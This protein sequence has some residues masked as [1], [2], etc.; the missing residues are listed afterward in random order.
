M[1]EFE[2]TERAARRVYGTA[3]TYYIFIR[4]VLIEQIQ[5]NRLTAKS[6]FI[7][8]L[9]GAE[10]ALWG[11]EIRLGK[12]VIIKEHDFLYHHGFALLPPSK[13][14]HFCT[15]FNMESAEIGIGA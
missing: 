14:N 12:K 7:W 9:L 1:G 10:L 3:R 2:A 15:T 4:F 5:Y 13:V 11:S 8:Q 6:L